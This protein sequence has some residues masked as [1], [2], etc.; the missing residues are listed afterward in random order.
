[1]SAISI[2]SDTNSYVKLSVAQGH[3]RGSRRGNRRDLYLG[4]VAA[5]TI[6]R[7]HLKY[8]KSDGCWL[9]TGLKER[10]GYGQFYLFTEYNGIKVR[11]Y[12]HRIALLLKLGF[13]PGHLEVMHSCDNPSCVN[14]DHLSLGTHADNMRDSALKGRRAKVKPT[15]RKIDAAGVVAIRRNDR[16]SHEWAD[17]Y[18]VCV[19][20]INRIRR[21]E[22][23]RVD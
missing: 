3:K 21:G 6:A 12:A 7:F 22:K 20:H 5:Q 23:R 18:G 13:L 17:Y 14:P 8:Q 16:P 15:I 2:G 1:M 4:K 10:S 11:V 9:W 19:S